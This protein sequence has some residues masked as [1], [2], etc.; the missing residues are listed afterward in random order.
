MAGEGSDGWPGAGDAPNATLGST[1]EVD[2]PGERV[3]ALDSSGLGMD[4]RG[5]LACPSANV[6]GPSNVAGEPERAAADVGGDGTVTWATAGRA[7]RRLR[8]KASAPQLHRADLGP[9]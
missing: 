9:L 4:G 3:R 8:L 5:S 6:C 1:P 7:L 2:S